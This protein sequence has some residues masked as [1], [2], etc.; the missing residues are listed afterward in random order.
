MDIYIDSLDN[1][2]ITRAIRLDSFV[3]ALSF[4]QYFEF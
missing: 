2:P 4:S 3:Y 1:N